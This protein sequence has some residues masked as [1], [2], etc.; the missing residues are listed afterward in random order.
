[1]QTPPPSIGNDDD[2][3]GADQGPYRGTAQA[4]Q[5]HR[6]RYPDALIAAVI[7][8]TGLTMHDT[9]VDVA[10]GTGQVARRLVDM[11]GRVIAVDAEVVEE[12]WHRSVEQCRNQ[13]ASQ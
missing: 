13:G 5:Q 12:S 1:M 9:V 11:A 8:R 3:S 6:R 7:E 4:Y 2:V 10:C